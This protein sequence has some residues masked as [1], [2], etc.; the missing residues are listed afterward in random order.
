LRQAQKFEAIGQPAG[1]VAHHF[2]KVVSLLDKIIGKDI[3]FRFVSAPLASVKADP[4]QIE[5]VLMKLCLNAGDAMPR[6]GR[7]L[8]ET[9]MVELDK[10]YCRFYPYV[11]PVSD[12]AIGMDA[13]TREH[14]FEPFFTTKERGKS[15]EM[16]LATVYGIVR[17]TTLAQFVREMLDER[18]EEAAAGQAD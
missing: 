14:I 9:E 17:P 3:E 1:G 13:E 8:I 11:T 4:T 2:N 16:G 5:Q 12:T 6:G 15:M 10:P 18:P 7:L